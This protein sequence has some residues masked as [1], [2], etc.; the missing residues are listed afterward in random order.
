[1][2]AIFIGM[3]ILSLVI[4]GFQTTQATKESEEVLPDPGKEIVAAESKINII[5]FWICNL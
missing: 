1:V 2:A 3:G 5:C 4:G